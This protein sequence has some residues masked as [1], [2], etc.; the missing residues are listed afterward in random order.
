MTGSVS[1]STPPAPASSSAAAVQA[2]DEDADSGDDSVAGVTE[3]GAGGTV[4]SELAA[5]DDEAG[6]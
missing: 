2:M 1:T 6:A 4:E 3:A 5:D